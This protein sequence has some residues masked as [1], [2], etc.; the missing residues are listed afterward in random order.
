MTFDSSVYLCVLS[1]LRGESQQND[2]WIF[3]IAHRL[4]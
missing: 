4:L 3:Q 1:G 2:V